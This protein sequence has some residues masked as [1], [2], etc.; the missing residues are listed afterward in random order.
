MKHKHLCRGPEQIKDRRRKSPVLLDEPE[1][2]LV[3]VIA[4][5]LCLQAWAYGGMTSSS[6]IVSLGLSVVALL[7]SLLPRGERGG[8]ENDERFPKS[9]RE[10]LLR[11]PVFWAGVVMIGY[12]FLQAVNPAFSYQSEGDQW[13]LVRIPHIH[14]LPMGMQVPFAQMNP[15]RVLVILGACWLKVCA[16]WVGITRRRSVS[17][18]LTVL[19][20]NAFLLAVV[21][22]LQR[23]C[24]THGGQWYAT[25]VEGSVAG[26]VYKNHAAAY[27]SLLT[28][29][30]TGLGLRYFIKNGS[31]RNSSGSL[32]LFIFFGMVMML[33]VILSFS[34]SGLVILGMA[35]LLVVATTVWH[36]RKT[37]PL[38]KGIARFATTTVILLALVAGIGAAV[39]YSDIKENVARKLSWEGEFAIR[40]R[41]QANKRGWEMFTDQWLTGWGAGCFRYGFTK[42]QQREPELLKWRDTQLR[43]E[44]VHDDWL[45]LLI[46]LGV[47]GSIP[48][49]F[50]VGY[51]FHQVVSL[52][53]WDHI[54]VFPI[55]CGLGGL[56][57]YGFFDFPFH[58]PAAA[59]TA[60]VL[61]PAIIKWGKSESRGVDQ[62]NSLGHSTFLPAKDQIPDLSANPAQEAR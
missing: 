49:L 24:G 28:L 1:W 62:I 41:L 42:Y 30:T 12:V 11:F 19:S 61:L 25:V 5:D 8:L 51:W 13:W 14:W 23:A 6:Q 10:R 7:F 52:R 15:W 38:N 39:G 21:G 37:F 54:A 56:T 53:L 55:L 57:A 3:G 59:S 20:V 27:F 17:V 43:W 47:L 9:C 16:L 40:S 31:R 4:L 35:L 58:N 2:V 33:A 45:E 36:H 22:I 44:N 32:V 29:V 18:L 46:E 60:C 26:I 50:I 34:L 48:V